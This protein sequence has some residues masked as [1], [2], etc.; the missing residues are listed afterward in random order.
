[1]EYGNIFALTKADIESGL[2]RPPIGYF[3]DKAIV[4]Y[5]NIFALT[6]ADIESRLACPLSLDNR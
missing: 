5:G 1:M 2:A 3:I 6:K 4:E